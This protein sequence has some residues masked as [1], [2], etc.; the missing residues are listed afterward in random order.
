MLPLARTA[1]PTLTLVLFAAACGSGGDASPSDAGGQGATETAETN[2]A[3]LEVTEES[4]APAP[5]ATP[6]EGT[7]GTE[8][9]T[10]ACSADAGDTP[11]P[12]PLEV[13]EAGFE[14]DDDGFGRW[15][16][17]VCNPNQRFF[18]LEADIGVVYRNSTGAEIGRGGDR[19]GVV[20]PG[21]VGALV[22]D[23]S[24]VHDAEPEAFPELHAIEASATDSRWERA[25][26]WLREITIENVATWMLGERLLVT[27]D[28]VSGT[29]AGLHQV[30]VAVALYAA[31]TIV[32]ISTD[33]I[34]F[35]PASGRAGFRLEFYDLPEFDRVSA[36]GPHWN[37]AVNAFVPEAPA[38]PVLELV[39]A[40]FSVDDQGLGSWAAV[41]RNSTMAETTEPF[42]YVQVTFRN[43][44][45]QVTA[46]DFEI[47]GGSVG[48]GEEAAVSGDLDS[49]G[50]DIASIEVAIERPKTTAVPSWFGTLRSSV[51]AAPGPEQGTIT[52]P[53][54]VRS[55]FQRDLTYTEI[56]VVF[57]RDATIVGGQWVDGPGVPASGEAGS[58]ATIW[59]PP[60][61]DTVR[62]FVAAGAASDD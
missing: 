53:G 15:M 52:V 34:A 48:P 51:T 46:T 32:A 41:L 58:S 60:E 33:L 1:I 19:I 28:L 10:K 13:I 17:V 56:V 21:E 37:P 9:E 6:P 4:A 22:A 39:D 36:V 11:E 26:G 14:V 47:I 50:L 44:L 59:R 35:L 43:H 29:E 8:P 61:H 18:L 25:P 42:S 55:S 40:G 3:S 12:R 5:A 20:P 2:G 38:T 16:V 24:E 27:G 57:Y 54:D 45:G 31:D 62:A 49:R 23:L 30:T 7:P